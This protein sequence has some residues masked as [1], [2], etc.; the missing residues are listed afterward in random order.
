M[1][2]KVAGPQGDSVARRKEGSKPRAS[3]ATSGARAKKGFEARTHRS[4]PEAGAR[5]PK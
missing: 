2:K 1:S 5:K 3:T 4:H